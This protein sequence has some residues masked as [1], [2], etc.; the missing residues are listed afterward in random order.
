MLLGKGI[1]F[2][3]K[4]V[5]LFVL[6]VGFLSIV[7]AG[8]FLYTLESKLPNVEAIKEYHPP[9]LTQVFDRNG[10]L[11]AEFFKEKRIWVPLDKI[12]VKLQEA[13]IA[14]EDEDFYQHKGIDIQ[15]ILRAAWVDFRAKR[16]VQGGS[17]ITQQVAKR[18]FLS[19]EKSFI[20]KAKEI[21][22]ACKLE[23]VLTK[24]QIL[25]LYLNQVY[26]GHGAYG[27]EAAA[28]TY[29]G[30]HVWELSLAECATLAGL[31]KSP[32]NYSPFLNPQNAYARR[33][34]V[35]KR[36]LVE[37]YIT[38]QEYEE[39]LHEPFSLS[40]ERR[41]RVDRAPYF[42]EF[43]RQKLVERYGEK[44]VLEGGLKVYSTL[45]LNLQRAAQKALRKGLEVVDKRGGY[46]GPLYHVDSEHPAP[47]APKEI[48]IG[49]VYKGL[50]EKITPKGVV[51]ALGKVK[52][53]ITKKDMAWAP[54]WLKKWKGFE[55]YLSPGDVILVRVKDVG[56]SGQL[57]LA[58]EQ[59]VSVEGAVLSLD[60]ATG[61]VLAMV[62]GYSFRRSKFN[63]AVQARR[64]PGSGFKPII[65]TAAMASGF[66]PA[67]IIVD[68]PIT[69]YLPEKKEFWKPENYEKRFYGPTRLRVALAHSRNVVTIKLLKKIG[70]NNAIRYAR[71]LGIR[72]ELQP[73]LSLALGGSDVT[74][75]DMAKAYATF[76]TGGKLYSLRYI[77]KVETHDGTLLEEFKPIY[78]Q[79]LPKDLA[80][81]MTSMLQSVV[82]EGTGRKAKVLGVPCG[83][84]TGTTNDYRDA[85][86]LGFTTQTFTGVYVGRDNH[87]SIGEKETGARAA[88]PIWIDVMKEAIKGKPIEPFAIPPSVV[89]ARIDP[90]NG[91]LARPDTRNA[92]YEVFRKGTEPKRFTSPI[93][94]KNIYNIGLQ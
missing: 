59:K 46:R 13:F 15:G 71:L 55:A 41:Y 29:F 42:D 43:I 24:R 26:F 23:K 75:W 94:R 25:E 88:L 63:R 80:Y 35:L 77:T 45:D 78:Q 1:L 72:G 17:T 93:V 61:D 34:H 54:G 19:P 39:A 48:S 32:G 90:R 85:W 6:I 38:P 62:G 69:F 14:V 18:M 56:Y 8:A 87:T 92:F 83:G 40:K 74:L 3:F 33:A 52:G 57:R 9:L 21:L 31:P 67:S 60:L 49:G 11:I 58:L 53:L 27:V 50:V 66:T 36:M 68:S 37:N 12:P 79:V 64:Q 7:A 73:N 76:P 16:I 65:Y 44:E 4:S 47:P 81:I 28:L 30:K 89:F 2:L 70:V 5:I 84:K 86:F 91:L 82:K 20:R 51:V 22:L 10:E